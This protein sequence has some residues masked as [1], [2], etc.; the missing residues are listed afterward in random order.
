MLFYSFLLSLILIFAAPV[1]VTHNDLQPYYTE[2]VNIITNECPSIKYTNKGKRNIGF[3]NIGGK[4]LG[5]CMMTGFGYTIM[6]DSTYWSRANDTDKY[7][8]IMHELT[9]CL[10]RE[11]HNYDPDNYMFPSKEKCIPKEVILEQIKEYARKHCE[12]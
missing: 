4:T 1:Q 11:P 10:L 12:E 8:V 3:A 2:F 7:E 9:H 6:I 5:Y